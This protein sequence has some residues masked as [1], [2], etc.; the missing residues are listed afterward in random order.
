MRN[1]KHHFKIPFFLLEEGNL[2]SINVKRD[3]LDI[4]L[5]QFCNFQPLFNSCR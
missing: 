5:E 1:K 2:T 3:F 4:N